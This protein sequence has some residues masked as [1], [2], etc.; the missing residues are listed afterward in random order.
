M[1]STERPSD[2]GY[3]AIAKTFHW[4]V[5]AL[6]ATQYALGWLMPHVGRNTKPEGLIA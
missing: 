6:L 4:L 2:A 3:D 5:F 1:T